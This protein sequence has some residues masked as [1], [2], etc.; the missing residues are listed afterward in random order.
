MFQEPLLPLWEWWLE[1]PWFH[2][3][4]LPEPPLHAP[5]P[6]EPRL[7]GPLLLDPLREPFI[8]LLCRVEN[9]EPPSEADGP[10]EPKLPADE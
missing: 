10:R 5:L 6:Q 4:L 3:P 7:L 8:E 1:P 2:E 9:V